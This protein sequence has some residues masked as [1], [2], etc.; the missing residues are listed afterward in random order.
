[1]ILRPILNPKNRY[2]HIR[3]FPRARATRA[4]RILLMFLGAPRGS[5]VP[6]ARMLHS[7]VLHLGAP[8]RLGA[9]GRPAKMALL[10]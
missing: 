4:R 3:I 6:S 8:L 10:L 2:K 7:E 5:E 9:R 1:M